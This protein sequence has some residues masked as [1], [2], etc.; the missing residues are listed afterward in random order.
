M[1]THTRKILIMPVRL[2][3]S[4]VKQV[5]LKAHKVF[6]FT[7]EDRRAW[8]P[9]CSC[10]RGS[11]SSP[12][13][14]ACSWAQGR[15]GPIRGQH[16]SREWPIRAHLE[17][18]PP[19]PVQR[20][21]VHEV[22]PLELHHMLLLDPDQS[23]NTI[24]CVVTNVSWPG[25]LLRSARVLHRDGHDAEWPRQGGQVH[26]LLGHPEDWG[27]DRSSRHQSYLILGS[28]QKMTSLF[29]LWKSRTSSSSSSLSVSTS[30]S[31][32]A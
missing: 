31:L 25:V 30:S 26:V 6:K 16:W 32:A 2:C 21:V 4:S 17:S 12:P 23:E 10:P 5:L 15:P 3:S 22:L 14:C 20:A 8:R 7:R 9:W 28:F 19:Q 1:L 13:P 11:C 29:C 24:I 27:S 18:V